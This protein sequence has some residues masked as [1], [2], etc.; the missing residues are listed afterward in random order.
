MTQSHIRI[1][2]RALAYSCHT[3]HTHITFVHHDD[4]FNM[5][6][7]RTRSSLCIAIHSTS[8]ITHHLFLR[9]RPSSRGTAIGRRFS[10]ISAPAA[11]LPTL[12][13]RLVIHHDYNHHVAT[14]TRNRCRRR[15]LLQ[16]HHHRRPYSLHPTHRH[17]TSAPNSRPPPRPSRPMNADRNSTKKIP[18]VPLAHSSHP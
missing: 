12:H 9:R 16:P 10:L 13:P 4:T 14:P 15:L 6:Y 2:R 3:A 8:Y 7:H 5:P 18:R 17:T 1:H 11:L